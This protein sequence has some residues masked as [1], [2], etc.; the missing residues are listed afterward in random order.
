MSK[1]IK[2]VKALGAGKPKMHK[3]DRQNRLRSPMHEGGER[4]PFLV[5]DLSPGL[6]LDFHDGCH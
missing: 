1:T 6:L 3:Q 5:H 2:P 4:Y